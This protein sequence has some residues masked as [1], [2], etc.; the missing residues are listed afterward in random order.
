MLFRGYVFG[1]APRGRRGWVGSGVPGLGVQGVDSRCCSG[2]GREAGRYAKGLRLWGVFGGVFVFDDSLRGSWGLDG[3]HEGQVSKVFSQDV[4]L[5]L[6]GKQAV[7][8][9]CQGVA[10]F[11]DVFVW[12][13][14]AGINW[15]LGDQAV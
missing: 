2:M 7:T 3:G 1:V 14:A 12:G 4:A 10:A 8:P 13:V 5:G 6:P 9:R 11:S 15:E